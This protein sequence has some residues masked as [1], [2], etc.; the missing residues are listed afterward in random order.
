[1][2][3]AGADYV[4]GGAGADTLYGKGAVNYLDGGAGADKLVGVTGHSYA[5]YKDATA[6][7]TVDLLD[8]AKNKGD[9]AGD[10]Y[11][12]IHSVVGS[13]FNDVIIADN[14]GDTIVAGNGD[15][16]ITGGAGS[17]T[18][19]A[20]SGHDV[21]TGGGGKDILVGSLTGDDTY[22]YKSTSNSTLAAPDDISHWHT[23]DKI[24][25]SAIDANTTMA[26]HQKFTI[27][28]DTKT[29][30]T[31]IITHNAKLTVTIVS[32]YTNASGVAAS[33]IYLVGDLTLTAS[34]FIL[35][36]APAA[37]SFAEVSRFAAAI[38]SFAPV[39]AAT[40][41]AFGDT[42]HPLQAPLIQHRDAPRQAL[43]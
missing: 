19:I 26:G 17:D 24:D 16:T 7:V 10:T 14:H 40:P 4:Y 18:I 11:T 22:V 20:G 29:P 27:G 12:N 8:P 38:A 13:N 37:Q 23:G 2:G 25:L 41:T 39:P 35:T 43:F 9:A 42:P 15:D 21:I 28:T 6:G 31:I 5:S 34:D 30:G 1:V 33:R 3:G 32:L 36:P